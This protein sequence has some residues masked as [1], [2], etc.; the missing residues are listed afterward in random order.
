MKTNALAPKRSMSVSLLCLI[1]IALTATAAPAA[2][3]A[4][5]VGQLMPSG[6][7][8]LACLPE[9]NTVQT[10]VGSGASY[11]L[12]STGVITHWKFLGVTASTSS[13]SLQ[14]WRRT[15]GNTFQ[16][17]GSSEPRSIKK[18]VN[19]FTADIAAQEGDFIGFH[20]F[21]EIDACAFNRGGGNKPLG[22]SGPNPSPGQQLDFERSDSAR[23]NIQ[24]TLEPDADCDG[25]GDESQDKSISGGCLPPAAAKLLSH[26]ARM[27]HGKAKLKV[28]CL[29]LGGNCAG[30]MLVLRSKKKISIGGK[31]A[32]K[33]VVGRARFSMTAGMTK[34]IKVKL[35][36][37]ARMALKAAIPIK[38]KAT[39]EASSPTAVPRTS[40]SAV[41]IRG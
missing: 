5:Q 26:K 36:K 7:K 8:Q 21:G 33:I 23:L 10:A 3:G 18:G 20:T 22:A 37:K 14:V 6:S 17:V 41:K 38:A 11:Q 30:N 34:K 31:P 25:L 39:I 4:V 2:E 19:T 32:A 16:L 12:P 15:E 24:A 1:V 13:I 28:S 27:Q 9:L 29:T 35:T 40:K